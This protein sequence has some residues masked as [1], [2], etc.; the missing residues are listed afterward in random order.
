M[1]TDPFEV[2]MKQA[3]ILLSEQLG[4]EIPLVARKGLMRVSSTPLGS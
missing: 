3:R 1:Q 4:V 2:R